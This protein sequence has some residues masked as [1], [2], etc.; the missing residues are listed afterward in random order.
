MN[1]ALDPMEAI[2][3]FDLD[4]LPD[5][6]RG[7]VAEMNAIFAKIKELCELQEGNTEIDLFPTLYR[8]L[9]QV[10]ALN[11][12]IRLIGEGLEDE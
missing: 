11:I 1:K 6:V 4:H 8:L 2:T 5:D 12:R 3:R 10:D 7:Y 9:G